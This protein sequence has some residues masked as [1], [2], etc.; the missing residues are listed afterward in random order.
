MLFCSV[1]PVIILLLSSVF[2]VPVLRVILPVRACCV[3]SVFSFLLI[4]LV[5]SFFPEIL[6]CFG[7]VPCD[8]NL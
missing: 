4:V 6:P 3:V 5:F 7:L 8:L 2:Y 1:V